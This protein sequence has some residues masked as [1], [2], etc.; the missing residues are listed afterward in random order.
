MQKRLIA[1]I[2]Q[3]MY[4]YY[5]LLLLLSYISFLAVMFYIKKWKQKFCLFVHSLLFESRPFFNTKK[6]KN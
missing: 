3:K 4:N 5:L 2:F 6:I 1:Y